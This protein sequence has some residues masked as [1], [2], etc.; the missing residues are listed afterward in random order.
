MITVTLIGAG[1]IILTIF[2]E[3]AI[4]AGALAGATWFGKRIRALP[5]VLRLT[6]W[7]SGL[8]LW[9][10]LGIAAALWLWAALLLLLGEFTTIHQA[11]YFASVTATTVGYGDS[12]LS[13]QWNLLSGFLAAN[14]LI[15]FSLN[16]AFLFEALRRILQPD[17]D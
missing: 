7:L 3:S 5:L 17:G 2:I 8:S 10:L 13:P 12:L 9:L 11:M 16:T 4:I 6:I 1:M 15:L 14:G